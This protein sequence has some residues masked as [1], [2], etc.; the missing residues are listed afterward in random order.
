MSHPIPGHE[1][2]EN[3]YKDEGASDKSKFAKKYRGASYRHRQK[4]APLGKLKSLLR[5]KK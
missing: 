4:N 1:Y 5:K 3:E 2:G